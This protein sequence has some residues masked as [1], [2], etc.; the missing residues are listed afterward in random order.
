MKTLVCI[1]V[2]GGFLTGLAAG[3]RVDISLAP[4]D[5]IDNGT[6]TSP[7]T[8]TQTAEGYLR[9]TCNAYRGHI[10]Y[11]SK[12]TYNFQGATVRYKWRAYCGGSYCWTQDGAYP[13]GRMSTYSFSTHHSWAS[14]I[15][16]SSNTWIFTEIHFNNDRTWSADYS[17]TG[18]G[19]GGINRNSGTITE[20]NWALLAT[21]FLSKLVGDGY[22]NS[23]YYEIA[24]AYYDIPGPQVEITSPA[25]GTVFDPNDEITFSAAAT[26]GTPPYTYEWESD[27]DGVL[28]SGEIL[29][30]SLLSQGIH[31]IT[32]TCTDAGEE[33][34]SVSITVSVLVSP[35]IEPIAPHTITDSGSYTGPIPVLLQGQTGVSWTLVESPAGMTID[36]ATGQVFW[37]VPTT[38]GSPFTIT[39]HAENP[40][41][42][43][44]IS[45]QL[46]VIK[47]PTFATT[48]WAAIQ[49]GQRGIDGNDAFSRT[50][51]DNDGNVLAAGYIDSVSGHQDAAYLAKY[52][53]DGTLLW[54]KTI[55][56]PSYSGKA[57][58]NDRFSDVAS[59]S[60]NNVIVVGSKSGNWTGYSSGSYHTA[61]WVQ[62]YTPDGQTLLWEKLWQDTANSAWQAANGVCVD[63]E[64]NVY[65]S[66]NS[67]GAWGGAEHQWVIFKYDKNGNVLLGPI[68]TNFVNAYY[69]ADVAYDIAVDG[70][71]DIYVAGVRG[72]SGSD[73]GIYNNMDWH[74]RKFSGI[75]GSTLWQDTYGGA[76]LRYDYARAISLDN[77]GNPVVAGYTNTGAD[78]STNINYDW[79]MIKYDSTTGSR[80]WTQMYESR[81]GSSEVCYDI[82]SDEN[83]DSYVSGHLKDINGINQRRIA[84]LS[85]I[86]GST[87]G[88]TIWEGDTSGY[89]MGIDKRGDLL[90]AGGVLSN[91]LDN[92]AFVM[93]LTVASAVTITSPAFNSWFELGTSVNF[94]AELVGFAEPPYYYS[95]S[96]DKDGS[97]GT[98]HTL[99]I[100]T[101]SLGEHLITCRLDC[102]D[103]QTMQT[104][105]RIVIAALPQIAPLDDQTITEGQTYSG[106]IPSTN[107]DAFEVTWSLV[108]GPAGMI[109]NP[110]TGVVSWSNA[111]AGTL[112]YTI[113]IQ[114]QNPL[115][116]AQASW[117][118]TVLSLPQIET[119]APQIAVELTPF[120]SSVPVLLKGALPVTWSLVSGPALMTIDPDTGVVSWENP[121]PSFSAY[122]VT[123][124]ATNSVGSG[125]ATF[126]LAVYSVPKIGAIADITIVGGQPYSLTPVLVKGIPAPEWSLAEAPEQMTINSQTGVINWPAP[127]PED[128]VHTVTVQASNTVG[129]STVTYQIRVML[130]P[131]IEPMANDT[132]HEGTAYQKSI[133]LSQ[134]TAPLTFA[135]LGA[136]AGMSI[137]AATGLIT[138]A[139]P[140]G[141]YSPYTITVRVSNAVGADQKNYTLT[142]LQRPVIKPI[143]AALTAEGIAYT[144]PVPS[145]YQGSAPITWALAKGPSQ[146]TVDADTGVVHWPTAVFEGSPYTVR[147]QAQNVVG[148]DSKSWQV[149]IVQPP[150]IATY[151]DKIA[152]NAVTYIAAL[153]TLTQGKHVSWSLEE[154]PAGMTINVS[155]GQ[156]I[157]PS[158]V[159]SDMPYT[160]ILRA[161]N[162]AGS[163][164]ETFHLTIHSKPVMAAIADIE[165]PEN[166]PYTSP[167]AELLAGLPP[168]TFSLT[169]APAG[170]T[171]DPATGA[172]NWAKPT[173][174]GSPH[175]VKL[176]AANAYGTDEKTFSIVVP[177]GYA[178]EAWA[179]IEIAPSGTPIPIQGRAYYLADGTKAADVTVHLNVK[180]RNTV[181]V[182]KPI[183]NEQGEFAFT[184]MPLTGESGQYAISSGHPLQVPDTAQDSFVLAALRVSDS[185]MRPNIIEGQWYETIVNLTNPGNIDLTQIQA[186][187][188]SGPNSI[189]IEFTPLTLLPGDRTEPAILRMRAVD[190]SVRQSAVSVQFTS[191]EGAVAGLTY[192]VKVIPLTPEL[193]VYPVSLESGMTRGQTT[194]VSFE[195]FNKGGKPTPELSV[196]IPQAPWLS[197][198]NPTVIGVHQPED[199]TVVTLALTPD[200]TLPL[201]PYQGSI[202]VYGTDMSQVIPFTFNCISDQVGGLDVRAVDEYTYFAEGAPLVDN[203]QLTLREAFTH[204]ALYVNE[205]MPDGRLV[206]EDIPEGYYTLELQA[207]EHG[208]YRQ[209][210]YASPGVTGSITAFM[211]RELVKYTWTVVPTEVKD[212]YTV[213]LDTTFETNVPAPVVVVDPANVDLSKMVG[214]QMQVDFTITNHGLVAAEDFYL[215]FEDHPRY[216]VELLTD[217]K[218]RV[219]P[220][221][222]VVV[223]AIV[224]DM[225]YQMKSAGDD[226]PIGGDCDPIKGGGYYTYICGKDGKWK[227]V[228]LTLVNWACDLY[229]TVRAI[230]GDGGDDYDDEHDYVD[231]STPKNEGGEDKGSGKTPPPKTP[232]DGGVVKPTPPPGDPR[233]PR[234]PGDSPRNPYLAKPYIVLTAED[235]NTCD[236]CPQDM[237]F[238]I[239][240]CLWGFLPTGCVTSMFKGAYDCYRNC[241]DENYLSTG[242]IYSCTSSLVS[243]TSS[244]TGD[245]TGLNFVLNL[246]SCG[247]GVITACDGASP[248]AYG[249]AASEFG[250]LSGMELP[251]EMPSSSEMLE[252]LE[253]QLLRLEA[254]V[255]PMI[256][257]LGDPVW[258][259]GVRGEDNILS[260]WLN[261][262]DAAI[263]EG[264]DGGRYVS[265]TEMD[266]LATMMLPS[267]ITPEHAVTVCERWNRT[268]DYNLVGKFNT[269]DLEPGDNPDFI[270]SDVLLSHLAGASQASIDNENEGYTTLFGGLSDAVEQLKVELEVESKGVCAKVQLQIQQ[271]AVMT[272]T[273][274]NAMLEMQNISTV[275]SLDNLSAEVIITDAEGNEATSLFGIYP[276]VV[277]GISDVSGGGS[278]Q[279]GQMFKAQ[280]LM[281][282]TVDAAPEGETYY[283]AGGSIHYF[284]NGRA[285]TIP[286]LPDTITV[287]PDA[288]LHLKYFFERDVYADDPFT[289]DVIEPSVPFVLGMMVSNT[290]AGSAYNMTVQSAQPTIVRHEEDKDILIDFK[291]LDAQVSSE[292]RVPSLQVSLGT[293]APNATKTAVWSMLSSLLGEFIDYKASFAHTDTLGDPRLSLIQSIST[294]ELNRAVRA[295]RTG[296]DD[297]YDFLV[298]DITDPN[299]LPDMLH[300]SDGS[301]ES[302]SAQIGDLTW[303]SGS[304]D[305]GQMMLALPQTPS[306]LFYVRLP[307]PGWPNYTLT[308]VVR[309]DGKVL[310][311][312]NAWTTY[313]M[314]YPKEEVPFAE[315]RLHLFDHDGTGLYTLFY[316][317][318]TDLPPIVAGVKVVNLYQLSEDPL[319]INVIFAE[320]TGIDPES[321]GNDDLQIIG[322]N[323]KVLEARFVQVVSE[324]GGKT[325]VLYHVFPPEGLWEGSL[326]GLYNIVLGVDQ[327]TDTAGQA[328]VSGTIGGFL[329]SIPECVNLAV[330]RC[331]L[332]GQQRITRTIFERTYTVTVKNMCTMP[333]WNLRV[334]P[335][336][337]PEGLELVSD[338]LRYCR[339]P[340]NGEA[341]S[342]G[343]FTVRVDY[344]N[345]P[346][347]QGEFKW[348][349][350]PYQSSDVT[351]DGVVNLDDLALFAESWLG[352]DPCYDWSPLPDGN[353]SVDYGDFNILA[354]DWLKM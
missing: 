32:V 218:G 217:F 351:M 127:G 254:M 83:N 134:G 100:S 213:I 48:I 313:K 252:Q 89:L 307:N 138:L 47:A 77:D 238:A 270:A 82:V 174:I 39:L 58:Y 297:V 103:S 136:P 340:A 277:T 13:W 148:T 173:A 149:T 22:A 88:Q 231:D 342:Q 21:S 211:P 301:V 60:E 62:K 180:L 172:I 260:Q 237:A 296:D 166:K 167:S 348:R 59:D 343:T 338:D 240:E 344:D 10:Y 91:G 161:Q 220:G 4:A 20:A 295:D 14:S 223:P 76:T 126:S 131:V 219:G 147:I 241:T 272:R 157:W 195:V 29:Q 56:A 311:V 50:A 68:R 117:Q 54:S 221:E 257:L 57:E 75:D 144:G 284:V 106:P 255:N 286:I 192:S 123:I 104:T 28:G 199:V 102:G 67:F 163:D 258:Y 165:I 316:E 262:Y 243:I 353:G 25:D 181:R 73:G 143:A 130:P 299:R 97:L 203:A 113:T 331:D 71:K 336:V 281:V 278:L 80:L 135:L 38:S 111:V 354:E 245:L 350:L 96:S 118:L 43:D 224:Y 139:Y 196:L 137:D 24:E 40:K 171:I 268:L 159:A 242:C 274:F 200:E 93:L 232:S 352:D 98:G 120:T 129:S 150:V 230:V 193:A 155:T 346:D 119:P 306:G 85:G 31:T 125:T 168:V 66:G 190:A 101:L 109:I 212:V 206:L 188:V 304:P 179:D 322:S 79:L 65:V 345:P 185:K 170:M 176:K 33:T 273:G 332:V 321:L 108:D 115:G 329:V 52:G 197:M 263:A 105:T 312:E 198:N 152:G 183:T 308:Q 92:D 239:A 264:S 216:R 222:T 266:A 132:V 189:E 55:D 36:A 337:L 49:D 282:P 214:G 208:V 44:D 235:L 153:P 249:A 324:Q 95:W 234:G 347:P 19:N 15:V 11:R 256:Y 69:L 339:I 72:V 207:P 261:A 178:A 226:G 275:D 326:N 7:R 12:D 177:I 328:A 334:I 18:Y 74:V 202:Y 16:I 327:V 253:I 2:C 314:N 302:V 94:S 247:Y 17:Y 114:A 289:E 162:I 133:L 205:P 318:S 34:V 87:L 291:L 227:K 81:L 292:P 317:P 151:G 63:A 142:V 298:N 191:G 209:T 194:N 46:E 315:I 341:V 309:S 283:F 9:A 37:P 41:G 61:W 250:K 210:L 290:G 146:M 86:D 8:L 279:P 78:N 45:W 330:I 140:N 154:A 1:I 276:P 288:N 323:G 201:G 3:G 228:P 204:A 158:P 267:Q 244:C 280:W 169:Q 107:P 269:A 42:S 233:P 6:V 164:T 121:L 246:I 251:A 215:D 300:V 182:Y 303:L 186:A 320:E 156:M 187:K 349:L 236:P 26:G 335:Q 265:Q 112:P 319:P 35:V 84:K 27:I 225:T 333:I 5:W 53:P 51:I 294:H 116:T 128:S 70:D 229:Q 293:I 124:R 23:F 285:V 287:K 184:F 160:I 90:A 110:W 64:D 145:L 30:T 325:E 122:S 141:N 259:S 175:T 248:G 99:E 305:A 271:S 310:P